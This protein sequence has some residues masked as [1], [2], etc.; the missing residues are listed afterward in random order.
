MILWLAEIITVDQMKGAARS[1]EPT[2][3]D[4]KTLAVPFI[5]AEIFHVFRLIVLV[6][7][8]IY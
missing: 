5:S 1:D 8:T 4:H 2:E 7:G 3:N 6:L